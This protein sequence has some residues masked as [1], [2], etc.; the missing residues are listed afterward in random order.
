MGVN[1]SSYFPWQSWSELFIPPEVLTKWLWRFTQEDKPLWKIN[2]LKKKQGNRMWV[3]I[4]KK[5]PFLWEVYTRFKTSCGKKVR[6]LENVW[7]PCEEQLPRPFCYCKQKG[8]FYSWLLGLWKL[9]LESRLQKMP[10]VSGEIRLSPNGKWPW[11]DPLE[12]R[13]RGTIPARQPNKS[14]PF[15]WPRLIRT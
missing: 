3:D 2:K 4:S 13:R 9:I 12:F 5:L 1:C 10:A 7:T 14:S 15:T 8:S 11:H 6:F